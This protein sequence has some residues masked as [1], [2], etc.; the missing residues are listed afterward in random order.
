[1]AVSS[2]ALSEAK[3]ELWQEK[4]LHYY[5]SF[6]MMV[7]VC[8]LHGGSLV[9][10]RLIL[11]ELLAERFLIQK[12]VILDPPCFSYRQFVNKCLMMATFADFSLGLSR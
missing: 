5:R 12:P 10:V 9:L 4:P 11:A 2:S 3:F 6:N 8:S 1:M 7:L